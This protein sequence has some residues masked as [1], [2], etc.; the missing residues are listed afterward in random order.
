MKS[1]GETQSSPESRRDLAASRLLPKKQSI[2]TFYFY[3]SSFLF[4]MF[5]LDL[6]SFHSIRAEG[7]EAVRDLLV[8]L[9]KKMSTAFCVLKNNFN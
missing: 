1:S 4:I 9:Y 3:F 7:R 8:F 6:S 5:H 2:I